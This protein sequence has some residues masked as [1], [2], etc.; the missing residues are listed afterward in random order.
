MP[1]TRDE[2]DRIRQ[3]TKEKIRAAAMD[4]FIE[5]GY[6]AASI[7]DVAKKAGISKGLMYNYY[8]GKEELLA[9]AVQHRIDEIVRVMQEASALPSPSEQLKR[10]VEGALDNVKLQPKVHRFYLH[11]QSLPEED[12]VLSK[13]SEMLNREMADQ[14]EVQCGM[15][16]ELGTE[17]PRLRSLYF[18]STLHGAMLMITTY[19]EHYPVQEIK[20]Q[21]ICEYCSVPPPR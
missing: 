19:P 3:L 14:F 18:S 4:I 10:I 6:H 13:Y 8:K 1:R 15:F 7:D 17:E 20:E 5:R 9:E 2:N 21:M 12:K 16:A 11:L